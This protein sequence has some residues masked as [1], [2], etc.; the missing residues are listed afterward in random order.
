MIVT[1][2]E[3]ISFY[4][5]GVL[6]LVFIILSHTSY[7]SSY[8]NQIHIPRIKHI[9]CCFCNHSRMFYDVVFKYFDVY[10]LLI[11]SRLNITIEHLNTSILTIASSMHNL[12]SL[13]I[14][15]Y[16]FY[17]IGFHLIPQLT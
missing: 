11:D 14:H 10:P 13:Y 4:I 15:I 2:S 16:L 6:L 12:T 7:F 8:F 5:D 3:T 9:I 1:Y 17:I